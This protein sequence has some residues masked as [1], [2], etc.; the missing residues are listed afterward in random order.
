LKIKKGVN[1]VKGNQQYKDVEPS[2]IQYFTSVNGEGKNIGKIATYLRVTRCNA[3]CSFCDTEWH[4]KKGL[5]SIY[6]KDLGYIV[7]NQ[8]RAYN[9]ENIVLTGGEILLYTPQIFR[10]FKSL[11]NIAPSKIRQY[12]LESNG[13]AL[14]DEYV[15]IDL[16]KQFN[17]IRKRYH[18]KPMLTISPKY[19]VKTSWAHTSYTKEQMTSL[20]LDAL[21]NSVEILGEYPVVYKFVYDHTNTYIEFED[22]KKYIDYLVNKDV[23]RSDILLMPLTPEDP[24]GENWK[25]WKESKDATARKALE[26]GLR[27]SPRIHVDRGLK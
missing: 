5:P 2:I 3:D 27:Y 15:A 21:K 7:G 11:Q 8:M 20:Y 9:S 22:T 19:D 1:M 18:I 13:F 17:K 14:H 10:I 4:H 25:L 12:D 16:L 26:L 6:D 24:L 23:R